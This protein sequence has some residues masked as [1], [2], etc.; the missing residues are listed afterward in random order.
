MRRYL[1]PAAVLLAAALLAAGLTFGVSRLNGPPLR[2]A[3]G[4]RLG[5]GVSSSGGDAGADTSKSAVGQG[6][7]TGAGAG[8]AIGTQAGGGTAS[9]GSPG[10]PPRGGAPGSKP[11]PFRRPVDLST[12][13]PIS[14]AG[15]RPPQIE[16]RPAD[17]SGIYLP[18]S[19]GAIRQITI[20]VFDLGSGAK[21]QS[22][23]DKTI[24]RV[25]AEGSKSVVLSDGRAAYFGTQSGLY[26][27]LS[28][29]K[30]TLAYEITIEI[31][32]GRP[33]NDLQQAISI[34]E[35]VG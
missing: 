18:K 16:N 34:A 29:V 20:E 23:V 7:S 8:A 9:N 21:A 35:Q 3:V 26:A 15:Y 4:A 25:Y 11:A 5:S 32:S 28:W 12:L 1:L 27:V 14:L 22:F 17:A 2:A 13:L 30:G 19:K 33:T 6:S 24:K 31:E 10:A